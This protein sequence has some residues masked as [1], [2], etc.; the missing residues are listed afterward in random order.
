[1]EIH[2]FLGGKS[3]GISNNHDF[4]CSN[5]RIVIGTLKHIS[6]VAAFFMKHQQKWFLSRPRI[7]CG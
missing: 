6:D 2:L 1:M 3:R 4:T 5:I 7:P